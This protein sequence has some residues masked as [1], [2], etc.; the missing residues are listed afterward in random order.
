MR[1][2][3]QLEVILFPKYSLANLR[4]KELVRWLETMAQSA[5]GRQHEK[6]QEIISRNL[7]GY[8]CNL[9]VMKWGAVFMNPMHG[10]LYG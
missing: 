6:S 5:I 8:A 9:P 7:E 1:N 3:N 2:H 4:Q 10:I